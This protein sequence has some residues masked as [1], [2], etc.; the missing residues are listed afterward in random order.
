MDNLIYLTLRRAS[1]Q[2]VPAPW[3]G[4]PEQPA[5]R[6]EDGSSKCGVTQARPRGGHAATK[7]AS[8]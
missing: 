2:P 3:T 6:G 4:P 7:G 1:S 5:V 8:L